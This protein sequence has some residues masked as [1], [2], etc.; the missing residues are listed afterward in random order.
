[1]Q[2]KKW[3]AGL[4]ASVAFG[5]SDA[6]DLTN[7]AAAVEYINCLAK[8]HDLQRSAQAEITRA[9][10]STSKLMTSV[11]ISTRAKLELRAM[12]ATLNQLSVGDDAATFVQYFA[13]F[14]QQKIELYDTMIE[15]ASKMLGGPRPDIDL[16]K[17]MAAS[18]ETSATME[19]VDQQIFKLANAFFAVMIDVRPGKDGRANRLKIKRTQRADLLRLI[20]SR[21]GSSLNAKEQNWIVSGAWLMRTNL[22]KN[23]KASDESE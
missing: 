14:Q 15:I 20:E 1:M 21:F 16:G 13:D 9:T 7:Y 8:M 6:A 4:L 5:F 22:Q 11:R 17:L 2:A 12:I 23:F 10:D 3:I 19:N 18:A